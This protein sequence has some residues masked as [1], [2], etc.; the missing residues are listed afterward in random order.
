MPSSR[1]SGDKSEILHTLGRAALAYGIGRLTRAESSGKQ[2]QSSDHSPRSSK[3]DKDRRSSRH[4]SSG[5]KST[6]KS[7]SSKSKSKRKLKSESSSSSDGS[8]KS[9]SS[10]RSSSD[11]DRDKKKKE[12]SSSSSSRRHGG[13]AHRTHEDQSDLHHHMTQLAAGA[14]AFGVK[15]YMNHR[16]DKKRAETAPKPSSSSYRNRD[17]DRDRDPR[18]GDY[19][20]DR[21]FRDHFRPSRTPKPS[22]PA[23]AA[24]AGAAAAAGVGAGIGSRTGGGAA[25]PELSSALESL[26]AELQGTSDS[27]RRLTRNKPSHRNCEV[28]RGLVENEARIQARLSGLQTSVN[29]MR[30]LYPGLD[31]GAGSKAREGVVD[32]EGRERVRG[33]GYGRGEEERGRGEG[34]RERGYGEYEDGRERRRVRRR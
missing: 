8:A 16:R 27:I 11:R 14:L 21:G 6:S 12:K 17:R 10:H 23:Y 26:T 1:R 34:H 13:D 4:E 25:D 20:S 18:S 29:N 32:A 19:T 3:K 7:P 5:S 31:G 9:K 33:E 24:A 30:N 28:H 2:S 22:N 15:Q